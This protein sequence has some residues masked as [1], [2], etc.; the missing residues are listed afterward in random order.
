MT[1]QRTEG[2]TFSTNLRRP[3][4]NRKVIKKRANSFFKI[5]YRTRPRRL[6]QVAEAQMRAKD[7]ANSASTNTR[8]HGRG[9]Q[10]MAWSSHTEMGLNESM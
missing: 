8:T 4:K 6:E 2:R 10:A 3:R 5:R 9:A 7:D 1:P